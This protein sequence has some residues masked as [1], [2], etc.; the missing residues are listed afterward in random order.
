MDTNPTISDRIEHLERQISIEAA[1]ERVREQSVGMHRSEDV[2]DVTGEMFDELQSLGLPLLR[3]GIGIVHSKTHGEAWATS[4]TPEGAVVQVKG[5]VS[6]EDQPEYQ[7]LYLAW[8]KQAPWFKFELAGDNLKAFLRLVYSDLEI[9]KFSA[10]FPKKQIINYFGFRQGGLFAVASRDL[11]DLEG[12]ILKKFAKSFHLTYTRY[13]DLIQVE[14]RANLA[15][16]KAALS[17]IQAEVASMR[18]SEDLTYVTPSIWKELKEL[19]V[20]FSRCGVFIFDDPSESIKIFLT[21]PSGAGLAEFSM[22]AKDALFSIKALENWRNTEVYVETWDKKKFADWVNRIEES[23]IIENKESYLQAPEVPEKLTLHFVPFGQGSLYIGSAESLD[24]NYIG[25]VQEVAAVFH[26][27]YSRYEDFRA[28]EEARRLA[29]EALV[30]L[31]AV[32]ERLV[33]SEKMASLGQMAAGIAYEIKTPISFINNFADLTNEL[34]EEIGETMLAHREAYA[35][36]GDLIDQ[37][38]GNTKAI[39]RHGKM[40][41]QIVSN[42]QEHAVIDKSSEKTMVGVNDLISETAK[43][44]ESSLFATSHDL[45]INVNLD[46]DSNL[47]EARCTRK[48]IQKVILSI[49]SNAYH[50]VQAKSR[51]ADSSFNPSIKISSAEIPTGIEISIEDNGMGVAEDIEAKIFDPFFTTKPMGKGS[52]LGLSLSYEIITLGHQGELEHQ[53]LAAGEHD[54]RAARRVFQLHTFQYFPGHAT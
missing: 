21:D 23:G 8:E 14:E 26:V 18:T 30:N 12:E 47:G 25:I 31:R 39:I 43:M 28:K 41:S 6:F 34:A 7:A 3:C 51:N 19:G 33:H 22:P 53:N 17:R 5:H 13:Q 15:V 44:A 35:A 49:L 54:R 52:G 2:L 37:L 1:L 36:T 29:E 42:M 27:A 38:S 4:F 10:S 32:Q 48:D 16:R 40:A 9:Q 46:L 11:D 50:A 20:P 24:D 45:E